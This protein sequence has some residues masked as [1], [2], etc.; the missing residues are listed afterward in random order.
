MVHGWMFSMGDYVLTEENAILTYSVDATLN[1]DLCDLCIETLRAM[2]RGDLSI[3][4]AYDMVAS[5]T[6]DYS[7]NNFTL[8]VAVL[9]DVRQHEAVTVQH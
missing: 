6:G 1:K 8:I 7:Y 2:S 4:L 3:R 9:R 5:F